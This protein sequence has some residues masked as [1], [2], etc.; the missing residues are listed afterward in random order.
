MPPRQPAHQ[1]VHPLPP[2]SWAHRSQPLACPAVGGVGAA[3]SSWPP[4]PVV[5]WGFSS[6]GAT[7]S[8]L[9]LQRIPCPGSR[10]DQRVSVLQRGRSSSSYLTLRPP[11]RPTLPGGAHPKEGAQRARSSGR[12]PRNLGTAAQRA[13]SGLP[14]SQG[15]ASPAP[16]PRHA[17]WQTWGRCPRTDCGWEPP[18]VGLR[19]RAGRH[20]RLGPL[21]SLRAPLCT[22]LPWSSPALPHG[23]M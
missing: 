15:V 11:C 2:W 20:P 10:R 6:P 5:C 7:L 16:P 17:P 22:R 19:A 13:R 21:Q 18:P 8:L 12:S 1:P 14:G 4:V 23:T 9:S 3:A